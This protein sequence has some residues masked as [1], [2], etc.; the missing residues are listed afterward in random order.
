M[1][2]KRV[3]TKINYSALEGLFNVD[4]KMFDPKNTKLEKLSTDKSK[5]VS[6]EEDPDV[7]VPIDYTS[8]VDPYEEL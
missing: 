7:D 3:S 4:Q 6:I 5:S 8:D 2:K 1:L